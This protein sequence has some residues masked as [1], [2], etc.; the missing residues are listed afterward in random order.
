MG[1]T[2]SIE[3]LASITLLLRL[4]AEHYSRKDNL[5]TEYLRELKK[6]ARNENR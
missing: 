4:E 3:E 2:K 6:R 1:K 5:V